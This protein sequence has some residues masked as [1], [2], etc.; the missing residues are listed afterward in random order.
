[1]SDQM[2]GRARRRALNRFF[3]RDEGWYVQSRE[4]LLG[5]FARREDAAAQLERHKRLHSQSRDDED[6][7]GQV[8]GG[9]AA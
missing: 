4:G 5:P 6:G 1:M 3:L 9:S 7:K 2:V 8:P